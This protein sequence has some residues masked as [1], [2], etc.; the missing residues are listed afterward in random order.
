MDH[1]EWVK[2]VGLQRPQHPSL[3]L[4]ERNDAS[5]A[6]VADVEGGDVVDRVMTSRYSTLEHNHFRW[7]N[8]V[9]NRSFLTL[10]SVDR[11]HL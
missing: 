5:V 8:I 7:P 10:E 6:A 4:A 2:V 1:S 11:V 9:S 3:L